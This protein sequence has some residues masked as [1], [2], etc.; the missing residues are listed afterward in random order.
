M[1][2]VY[3][4]MKLKSS[5]FKKFT[6]DGYNRQTHDD[7]RI[8]FIKFLYVFLIWGRMKGFTADILQKLGYLLGTEIVVE[9]VKHIF[10][11]QLNQLSLKEVH[12][13]NNIFK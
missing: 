4:S 6:I 1:L 12:E 5:I 2:F 10:L 9:W 8:R 7:L 3:N 13:I 11:L